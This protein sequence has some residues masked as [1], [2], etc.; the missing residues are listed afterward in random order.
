MEEF[1]SFWASPQD[2][3][4]I[5]ALEKNWL[6]QLIRVEFDSASLRSS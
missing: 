4:I 1:I 6:P 3:I 5:A 2:Q